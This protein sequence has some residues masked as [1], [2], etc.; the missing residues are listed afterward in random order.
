MDKQNPHCMLHI[1]CINWRK[2]WLP[3]TV[4]FRMML[5]WVYFSGLFEHATLKHAK[6]NSMKYLKKIINSM[7]YLL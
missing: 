2:P 5:V 6:I 1:K 4:N 7:K 3:C